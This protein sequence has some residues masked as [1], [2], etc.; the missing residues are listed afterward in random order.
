[1]IS[2]TDEE[3]IYTKMNTV[4]L[5]LRERGGKREKVREGERE[6]EGEKLAD[7]NDPITDDVGAVVCLL[8]SGHGLDLRLLHLLTTQTQNT[9]TNRL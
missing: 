4:A 1:M 2:L 5:D 9:E 6:R 3:V 8:V 7:L